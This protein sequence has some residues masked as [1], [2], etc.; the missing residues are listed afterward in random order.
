MADRDSATAL[1]VSV[2]GEARA[3]V[4]PDSAVLSAAISVTAASRP[5]ALSR[6]GDRLRS[7]EADLATLGGAPLRVDTTRAPLTWS[8][9]SMSTHDE[10]GQDERTGQ[11]GPTGRISAVVGIRIT[12]R[13]FDLLDDLGALL[14]RQVSLDVNHVGWRVD[15]DNPGWPRVRADAVRAAAVRAADYAAALGGVLDS[16]EHLADAGLMGHGEPGGFGPQELSL[17][18]AGAGP[19]PAAPS[20][21]PVPQELVAVVEARFTATGVALPS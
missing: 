19:G 16:V 1:V 7:L 10:H 13:A 3:V 11:W 5:D 12:V 17:M 21:D 8:A 9:Q 2:R 14:A 4:D 20:L 18:R 6:A 15:E